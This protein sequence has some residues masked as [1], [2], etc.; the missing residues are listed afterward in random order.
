MDKKQKMS[1]DIISVAL[2]SG[3]FSED[4]LVDNMM[5]FLAAGHETTASS[6]T[7]AVHMM[8][9]HPEVQ[10][11]LRDEIRSNISSLDATIDDTKI[12]GMSYLQAV[13][14][15][16]LRFYAPVPVTLRVAA[17]DTSIV[18]QFIPKGTTIIMGAMVDKSEQTAMGSGCGR[19][20]SGSLDGP[21][22]GQLRWRREQLC[23]FDL[24]T[25]PTKFVLVSRFAIAEFCLLTCGIRRSI[26]FSR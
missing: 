13:C 17:C 5:T 6:F 24:P 7:W 26:F 25:R 22:T 16:V 21:W 8:C 12:D 4:K 2:E 18:G 19:V 20:Q 9:K 14:H 10:S 23:V 1:P 11:R 15:E 3:V